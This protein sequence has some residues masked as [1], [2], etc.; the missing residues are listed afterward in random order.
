MNTI[1]KAAATGVTSLALAAMPAGATVAHADGGFTSN[2]STLIKVGHYGMLSSS[3]KL[4]FIKFK[5]TCSPDVTDAKLSATLVQ[6]TGG[7]VQANTGVLAA[8]NAFECDGTGE[9]V[10]LSIRRPTGGFNWVKG[11]ARV[12]HATFAT[13]DPENGWTTSTVP[14]R[15]VILR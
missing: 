9:W 12:F 11:K 8:Y 4:A 10:W 5:V 2:G 15:T 14:G 1:T 13:E 3:H 7:N 6:V